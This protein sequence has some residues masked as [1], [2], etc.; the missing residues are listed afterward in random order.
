VGYKSFDA[1]LDKVS[2]EEPIFVL[3]AQD[4]LAA[5]LVDLW[6]QRVRNLYRVRKQTMSK[7]TATK[8]LE[9]TGCAETMRKWPVRKVPD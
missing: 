2:E 4:I 6:V 9:A 8:L 7:T 5:E 3:R 1:C